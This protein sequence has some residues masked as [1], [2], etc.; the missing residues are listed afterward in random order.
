MKSSSTSPDNPPILQ[1]IYPN[2]DSHNI[3]TC[4]LKDKPFNNNVLQ[5]FL[6]E[7]SCILIDNDINMYFKKWGGREKK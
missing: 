5:I 4:N 1:S 2:L 3:N 6:S 7:V